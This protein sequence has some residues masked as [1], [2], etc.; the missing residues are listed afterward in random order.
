MVGRRNQS[1]GAVAGNVQR[2]FFYVPIAIT[3]I[4]LALIALL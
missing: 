2:D 1:V 4:A 3:L